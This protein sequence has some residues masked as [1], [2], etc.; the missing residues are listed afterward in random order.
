MSILGQPASEISKLMEE[1][2][3]FRITSDFSEID[4]KRL[5]KK[6]EYIKD[7]VDVA[8][9]FG[10]LGMIACLENDTKTMRS[11]FERAIQ[12]SGSNPLH[13]LNYSE[14]LEYLGL[15]NEAYEY[16][17]KS[18]ER[19]RFY[20]D[21]LDNLIEMSC[22]LSK[23]D[24]FEHYLSAW[25]KLT[26]KDHKLKTSLLFYPIK[27]LEYYAFLKKYSDPNVLPPGHLFPKDIL[28]ACAPA[29]ARIFG[30]PISV[31]LEIMPDSSYEPNLVAFIQWIG[32][33][34]DGMRRDDLFE[35]WYIENGYDLK[36][37]LVFF[38][39]EFVGE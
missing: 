17:L 3:Q 2:N 39:I 7:N 9:G 27:P 8:E 31:V 26:R 37:D 13:M 33:M 15:I 18:Y 36:T 19:D 25:R 28:D 4:L 24:E 30:T 34:E 16:A 21:A 1:L 6:A 20:S 32:E 23:Q 11:Y 35:K 10:L 29:I 22:A 12:Q 5:K 14:S 38:D